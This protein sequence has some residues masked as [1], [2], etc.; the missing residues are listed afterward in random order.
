MPFSWSHDL[1][2]I[3]LVNLRS[4]SSLLWGRGD[5]PLGRCPAFFLRSRHSPTIRADI[6]APLVLR[7]AQP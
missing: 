5:F 2:V 1:A 4:D 7:E 6:T 3:S